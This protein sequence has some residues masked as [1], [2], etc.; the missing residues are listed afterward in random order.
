MEKIAFTDSAHIATRR[1]SDRPDIAQWISKHAINWASSDK[2]LDTLIAPAA[3]D[4]GKLSAGTKRHEET[5]WYSLD[6]IFKYFTSKK[7]FLQMVTPE[8]VTKTE[9]PVTKTEEPV[10][11]TVE[12]VTKIEEP[13]T[14]TDEVVTK[15]EEVVSK[16][17]VPV[18]KTED[19]LVSQLV[20]KTEDEPVAKTEKPITMP[21]EEPVIKTE[22]EPITTTEDKP[23]E[24]I[25]KPVE[26]AA[27]EQG[28]DKDIDKR[29]EE[30]AHHQSGKKSTESHPDV[31]QATSCCN[32]I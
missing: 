5:S 28:P 9:E 22:D 25:T 20:V 18:T 21:E 19:E 7:D 12:V 13:V 4:A 10:T 23:D 27:K 2:P 1:Y 24:P 30:S 26:P 11:K 17:E 32:I 6:S 8:V 29:I 3:G 16:T 14:K 31:E 15:T